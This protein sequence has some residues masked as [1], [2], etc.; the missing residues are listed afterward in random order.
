M[1]EAALALQKKEGTSQNGSAHVATGSPPSGHVVD[2][3]EVFEVIDG[4]RT[5][6]NWWLRQVW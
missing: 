5:R 4:V 2:D 1:E 6:L 3:D